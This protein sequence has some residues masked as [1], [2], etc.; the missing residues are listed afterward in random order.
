MTALPLALQT[1]GGK[2]LVPHPAEGN[3]AA[4]AGSSVPE[5][6]LAKF[7]MRLSFS[8]GWELRRQS[9]NWC[10]SSFTEIYNNVALPARVSPP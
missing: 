7:R 4:T 6:P 5:S 2:I 1:T 3:L 9:K 8:R 10:V